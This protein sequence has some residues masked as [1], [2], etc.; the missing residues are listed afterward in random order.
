[1]FLPRSVQAPEV[2]GSFS[3]T[4]LFAP[5]FPY[6]TSLSTYRII[7]IFGMGDQSTT[8]LHTPWEQELSYVSHNIVIDH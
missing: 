6:D 4:H 8:R 1:M 3:E 5:L 7:L 2:Q